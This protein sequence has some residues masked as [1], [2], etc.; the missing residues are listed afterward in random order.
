MSRP[1]VRLVGLVVAILILLVSF[2]QHAS[3]LEQ[4]HTLSAFDFR[5]THGDA[6]PSAAAFAMNDL[7]QKLLI[8]PGNPTG[9][10]LPTLT[11][12]LAGTSVAL[13]HAVMPSMGNSTLRAELGQATWRLLHTMAV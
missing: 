12:T 4:A 10:Q 13:H 1:V 2:R 3:R 8:P 11:E 7:V 6:A 5:T 9:R